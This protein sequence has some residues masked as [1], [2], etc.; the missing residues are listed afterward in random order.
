MR[1]FWVMTPDNL[2][3]QSRFIPS[4]Y[5]HAVHVCLPL[6]LD[7]HFQVHLVLYVS[8]TWIGAVQF[9]EPQPIIQKKEKV[10]VPVANQRAEIFCKYSVV[11]L[12]VVENQKLWR[13]LRL[14]KGR[15]NIV[16]K[17]I[18]STK[19]SYIRS[20]PKFFSQSAPSLFKIIFYVIKR[21]RV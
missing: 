5:F 2:Q 6:A 3:S 11:L 10:I 19:L 7:S 12:W 8:C 9:N 4:Y 13:F 17:L 20:V 16:F 14:T 1:V 18:K 15:G 21:A